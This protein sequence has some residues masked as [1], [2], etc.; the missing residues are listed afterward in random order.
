MG[1][2]KRKKLGNQALIKAAGG[3]CQ[4]CG[5]TENLTAHHIIPLSDGGT[6]EP[7]NIQILCDWH[8]KTLH[9]IHKRK[10]DDR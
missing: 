6:N 1:K 9:G 7:E 10:R 4:R 5:S 8:Q 3:K 2:S